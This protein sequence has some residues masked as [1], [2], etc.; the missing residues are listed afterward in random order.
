MDRKHHIDDNKL[1]DDYA[2]ILELHG[3][4]DMAFLEEY[5]RSLP[6]ADL[7][8]DRWDRAKRLGFG[9]GS[10]IYDNALVFGP[11]AVGDHCWVGSSTV[12]DG[13][14]GLSIGNFCTIACGVQIYTHD[15]VKKT[16]GLGSDPVERSEVTIGDHVYIAPNAVVTKGV[17]IGSHCVIGAF[18]FVNSDIPDYSIVIG[19]PGKVVGSVIVSNSG[20]SFNYHS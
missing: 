5:Q 20:V 11:P 6:M 12:L 19:Q 16:V 2:K 7:F 8:L 14:G 13:T 10:S 1:L 3:K 17:S 18:S 4:L 15:N 9:K